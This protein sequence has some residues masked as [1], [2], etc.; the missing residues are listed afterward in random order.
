MKAIL[1]IAKE[2]WENIRLINRLALYEVKI[3]NN[4]N[5]LG[6]AWELITPLFF[7]AIYWFVF[8]FGIRGENSAVGGIPYLSWMSA[9]ITIWFFVHPAV[10]QGSKAIYTKIRLVSKMNFPSSIIPVY[11]MISRLYPHLL[12]LLLVVIYMQFT[13][14]KV[15]IYYL[16]FPYFIVSM[17]MLIT[18]VLLITSTLTTVIR[19]IQMFIQSTI[20]VFLYISPF[21]WVS[22]TLPA[23]VQDLMK[24]NPLYYLAEGYRAAFFGGS[25]YMVEHWQYSLYFWAVVVVLFAAGALLH[26][27]FRKH[28]IDFL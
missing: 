18:S 2:L 5:Y 21:L 14:Y 10:T 7:M 27:R 28:F 1:K 9:G 11:V 25:W 24:L 23:F 22:D 4:N 19:D 26:T 6:E 17:L 12:I 15:S 13:D 20:R 3:K 8:G 16:Q